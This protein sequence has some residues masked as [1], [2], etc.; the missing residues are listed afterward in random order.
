MHKNK[1]FS[2]NAFV[3]SAFRFRSFGLLGGCLIAPRSGA[4]VIYQAPAIVPF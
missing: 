2:G 4:L 3:R 1:R